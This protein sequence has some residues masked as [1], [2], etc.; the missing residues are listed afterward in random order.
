MNSL[1]PKVVSSSWIWR[2]NAGCV[3]CKT[4]DAL[5]KLSWRAISIKYFSCLG[6]MVRGLI[7][8][9][10]ID[11]QKNQACWR[12]LCGMESRVKSD[13]TQRSEKIMVAVFLFSA[14]H[15]KSSTHIE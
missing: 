5:V 3:M 12:C 15:D 2:D 10:A 13:W 1:T 8:F 14:D 6:V 7:Y 9:T 11:N 4:A